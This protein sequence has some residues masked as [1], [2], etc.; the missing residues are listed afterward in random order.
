MPRLDWQMWFA[1]LGTCGR[2]PW[3]TNFQYRLLQGS[4][5]VLELLKTNPFPDKAPL[6]VRSLV[7]DYR[8]TDLETKA[9]EGAWWKRELKGAYCP[10]LSLP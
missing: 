8:F 1:A 7:Y 6:Y 2:N 10:V 9:A 4:P 3:F 5:P